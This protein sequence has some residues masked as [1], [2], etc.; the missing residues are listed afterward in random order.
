VLAVYFVF[1]L[2]PVVE[3]EERHLRKLFPG[4]EVYARRMPKFWPRLRGGGEAGRRFEF[5]LYL[6]N[7]EYEALGAGCIAAAVL[8]WK[9]WMGW[10]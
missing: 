6:K 3:E 7:R 1:F 4:Y 2:L 10:A 9:I 5:S 8:I